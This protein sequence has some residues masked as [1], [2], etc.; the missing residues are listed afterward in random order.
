MRVWILPLL[1]GFVLTA[2]SSCAH[3]RV[4]M[5]YSDIDGCVNGCAVAA[6]GFPVPYIADY[7]GLSPANSADFVG[8][9]VGVDKIAWPRAA[10]AF[11][12]WTALA[13]MGI[14]SR[15]FINRGRQ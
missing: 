14:G 15:K 3:S 8:A 10:I 6:A 12:F 1:A 11:V 5:K 7:P 4:T 13:G 2:A 9:V